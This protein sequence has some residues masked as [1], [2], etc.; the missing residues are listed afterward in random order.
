MAIKKGDIVTL[1]PEWQDAGDAGITF[2]AIEDE[3]GGRVR[4]VAECG[5]PLNPTSIV[6]VDM[7]EAK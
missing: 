4:I 6:T 2:R 7:L 1:K 3:D 5:L